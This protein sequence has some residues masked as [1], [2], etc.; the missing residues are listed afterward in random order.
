MVL[1]HPP[2]E[3][4]VRFIPLFVS[5]FQTSLSIAGLRYGPGTGMP[6]LIDDLY[7]LAG[8]NFCLFLVGTIQCTRIFMYQSS[9]KGSS[10][11]ALKAMEKDIESSA[12]SV[13]RKAE[14]K[15]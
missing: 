6:M 1:R 4:A 2:K 3:H 7:S 12:K 10:T 8:V 9:Q 15:L 5:R 11:A 14:S 13:E